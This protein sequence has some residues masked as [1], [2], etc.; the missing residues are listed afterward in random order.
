MGYRTVEL[1]EGDI[2][3]LED[4]VDMLV[5]SAFAGDYEPV[6]GTVLWSLKSK[7]W[8]DLKSL[9]K[10]ASLDLRSSLS[11]WISDE[12]SSGPCNRLMCVEILGTD[13]D[14]ADIFNNVFAALI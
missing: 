5:V 13:F 7:Y 6:P 4:K 12:I 10:N 8:I 1:L 14:L 3:A 11:L 9:I 2:T